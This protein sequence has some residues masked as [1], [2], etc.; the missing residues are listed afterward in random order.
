MG[1][2]L[3]VD[4]ETFEVQKFEKR[5]EYKWTS[6]RAPDYGFTSVLSM[7]VELTETQMKESIREFLSNV[8]PDTG[9]LRN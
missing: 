4:G 5:Y 3:I 9:Y 6:G 2:V 1:T 8:D 7:D